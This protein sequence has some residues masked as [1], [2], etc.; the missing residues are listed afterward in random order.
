M[1]KGKPQQIGMTAEIKINITNMPMDN[2]NIFSR[3]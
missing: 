3:Y 2:N 1:A